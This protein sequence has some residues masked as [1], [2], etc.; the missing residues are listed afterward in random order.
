MRT[1]LVKG[2][3]VVKMMLYGSRVRSYDEHGRI[4][5][6]CKCW[7]KPFGA[8]AVGKYCKYH[9]PGWVR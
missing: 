6:W 9:N 1:I 7:R 2:A 8:G 3:T 5:F 4:D